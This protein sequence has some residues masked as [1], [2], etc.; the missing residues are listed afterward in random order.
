MIGR[1]TDHYFSPRT[2]AAERFW[3]PLRLSPPTVAPGQTAGALRFV[4]L[5]L[6][7]LPQS[8]KAPQE[9]FSE[10]NFRTSKHSEM[11]FSIALLPALLPPR[12]KSTQHTTSLDELAEPNY[13]S[14]RART[15]ST[16]VFASH[17][18]C[19]EIASRT[20]KS[21]K[22]KLSLMQ[23]DP[24]LRSG[25]RL[26]AHARKTPQLA[27]SASSLYTTSFPIHSHAF[28][29]FST[30]S[31]EMSNRKHKTTKHKCSNI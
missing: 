26:R 2:N 10:E 4:S 19:Q 17:T 1:N 5:A 23:T 9:R 18:K 28:C 3:I 16:R 11:H 13:Y 27:D 22:T 15:S 8:W 30:Q 24:S 7:I 25:F 29:E 20:T 21:S 6:H 12:Q 31:Q 14:K